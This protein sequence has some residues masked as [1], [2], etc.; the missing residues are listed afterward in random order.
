MHRLV[1]TALC[2]ALASC[3]SC[4]RSAPQAST[5]PAG[6]Y[7]HETMELT[8]ASH[9]DRLV[10]AY[11]SLFDEGAQECACLLDMR[12]TGPERWVGD[13]AGERVE[14][15]LTHDS[16][17]IASAEGSPIDLACCG[18]AWPGDAAPLSSRRPMTTCRTTSEAATVFLPV[19]YVEEPDASAWT[20][21]RGD[22]ILGTQLFRAFD[23]W[24]LGHIPGPDGLVGLVRIEELDCGD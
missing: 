16:L 3:R 12:R 7:G 20:T 1:T 6:T 10:A 5:V 11:A 19:P 15:V 9:G 18:R 21:Y 14:L 4:E 8:V 23:M 17:R 22:V 13:H 2:L 24:V